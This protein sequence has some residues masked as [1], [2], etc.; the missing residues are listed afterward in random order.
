[1]GGLSSSGLR[2]RDARPS[3]RAGHI[4][5]FEVRIE[6]MDDSSIIPVTGDTS[7]CRRVIL[8][9]L[10]ASRRWQA[11]SGSWP[12]LSQ[13]RK[14]STA[15]TCIRL[16]HL[17]CMHRV[18]NAVVNRPAR[19]PLGRLRPR[20]AVAAQSYLSLRAWIRSTHCSQPSPRLN[21]VG[22]G[23][24]I[25]LKRSS[26][27]NI[28]S[29]ARCL[30][31]PRGLVLSQSQH[32][33]GPRSSGVLLPVQT[34]RGTSIRSFHSSRTNH[35]H[36]VLLFL[37]PLLKTSASLTLIKTGISISLPYDTHI[38]LT[39]PATSRSGHLIPSTCLRPE[40]VQGE[41]KIILNS[42]GT[43]THHSPL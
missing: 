18:V 20:E 4:R 35:G 33:F 15:P 28:Q 37:I 21:G 1:M 32:A 29:G 11:K 19:G 26:T 17:L 2:I 38:E 6:E 5:Y 13:T 14:R 22:G 39:T 23:A 41:Q 43:R 10:M 8:W 16:D 24:P 3:C 27:P 40:K 7:C 12:G 34:T 36:P 25:Q 9:I 31:Q 42:D 30:S